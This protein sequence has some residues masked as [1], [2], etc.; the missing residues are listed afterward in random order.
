MAEAELHVLR[1]R[2]EGGI[3]NKA[4]RGEL[5]RGLPV[6]F[7]WGEQDGEVGL[8]PDESV[9]HTMCTVFAKFTELGSVRKVWLWFR[10]EE[11]SFP[12]RK[13]MKSQIRWA[14][15]YTAIHAV[16]TNP[17]YAGAYTYGKHHREQYVDDQG[18]L[19][20]YLRRFPSLRR[21]TNAEGQ[22]FSQLAQHARDPEIAKLFEPNSDV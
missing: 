20:K 2:L 17:V 3:R 10:S 1:A 6:G 12:T 14:P 18:R 16:L 7:V 22:P 8:D 19:R 5:R 15:T 13:P 21:A 9:V 11:L 4:A